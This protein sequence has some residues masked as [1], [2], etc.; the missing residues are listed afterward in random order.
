MTHLQRKAFHAYLDWCK[1]DY[2]PVSTD[3]HASLLLAMGYVVNQTDGSPSYDE[4]SL[5]NTL[6]A[7]MRSLEETVR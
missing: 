5:L 1:Q 6:A 7:A 2:P 4:R 3:I